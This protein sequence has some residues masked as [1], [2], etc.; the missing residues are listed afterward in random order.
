MYNI[1][2]RGENWTKK[3]LS[4]QQPTTNS[5]NIH[6]C[7]SDAETRNRMHWWE[8]GALTPKPPLSAQWH[9]VNKKLINTLSH[10]SNQLW[11]YMYQRACC[12]KWSPISSTM[13]VIYWPVFFTVCNGKWINRQSTL[14]TF[15]NKIYGHK[16]NS[17]LTFACQ[18]KV[19]M[20]IC[21]SGVKNNHH[22][23][24]CTPDALPVAIYWLQLIYEQYLVNS[25]TVAASCTQVYSNLN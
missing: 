22:W 19:M 2:A 10:Y 14:W 4:E 6:L 21:W 12:H 5:I 24:I 15:I 25:V 17:N 13:K 7:V 23:E 1:Q 18:K 3:N 8:A 9:D 20:M 11:C 16:S